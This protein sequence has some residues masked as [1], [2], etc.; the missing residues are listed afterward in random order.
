MWGP[1]IQQADLGEWEHLMKEMKMGPKGLKNPQKRQMLRP[2]L[3]L[4]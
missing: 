3:D 2:R 1:D 4:T